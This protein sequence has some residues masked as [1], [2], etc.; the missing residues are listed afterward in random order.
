MSAANLQ[1]V[2]GRYGLDSRLIRWRNYEGALTREK[3]IFLLCAHMPHRLPNLRISG[4]GDRF[5]WLR[6]TICTLTI[7]LC[8]AHQHQ[9]NQPQH[10]HNY[11]QCCTRIHDR[12]SISIADSPERRSAAWSIVRMESQ[13]PWLKSFR[14]KAFSKKSKNNRPLKRESLF[15]LLGPP[16]R[17]R[18]CA[19]WDRLPLISPCKTP[20][21]QGPMSGA[22]HGASCTLFKAWFCNRGM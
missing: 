8:R 10:A 16:G 7:R 19:H 2:F 5:D 22:G 11:Y 21:N 17:H 1:I 13:F 12:P 3:C 14:N 6:G 4:F 15:P 9:G 18:S 20:D